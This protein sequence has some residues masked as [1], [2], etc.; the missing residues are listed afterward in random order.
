MNLKEGDKVFAVIK[1]TAV[2][3][4]KGYSQVECLMSSAA[5]A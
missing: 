2:P 1:A 5:A 3:V 4:E